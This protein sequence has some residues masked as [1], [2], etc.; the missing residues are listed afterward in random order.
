MK[1]K[2]LIVL[3]MLMLVIT[4]S[5]ASP[6][7]VLQQTINSKIQFPV[8]AIEEQIEGVVFVEFEIKN[9]GKIEVLNCSSLAGELQS[10]IFLTLSA[11]KVTPEAELLGEKFLMKFDFKLI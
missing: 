11:M 6:Q 5:Y 7:S 4:N 8:V 1:T 2:I 9:D 3:A 10:Y